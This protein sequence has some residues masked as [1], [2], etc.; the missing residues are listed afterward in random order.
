LDAG[1]FLM[2][3]YSA[4]SSDDPWGANRALMQSALQVFQLIARFEERH[5]SLIPEPAKNC[6]QEFIRE[7]ATYFRDGLDQSGQRF[8]GMETLLIFLAAFRF[9]FGYL[10][11]DIEAAVRNLVDPAFLHLQRSIVAIRASEIVGSTRLAKEKWH[12]NG[13]EVLTFFYSASIRSKPTQKENVQTSFWPAM[14]LP[15]IDA[16]SEALVLAEWKMVR[17]PQDLQEVAEQAA[18]ARAAGQ[19]CFEE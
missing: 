16:S 11:T 13:W 18:P 6:L 8:H 15:E 4:V 17:N 3:A 2:A 9:E 5:A 19:E 7:R 12:V 14:A 10:L 1:N